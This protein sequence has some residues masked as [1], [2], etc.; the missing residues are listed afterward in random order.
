MRQRKLAG[1]NDKKQKDRNI[2]AK[3][4]IRC[5]K[6]VL[7]APYIL[8]TGLCIEQK[9]TKGESPKATLLEYV[10][11]EPTASPM[12]RE[13]STDELEPLNYERHVLF[14]I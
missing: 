5:K 10:G 14:V 1:H 4:T 12:L 7:S 2:G 3:G 9:K 11:V 13:R 6:G 8:E